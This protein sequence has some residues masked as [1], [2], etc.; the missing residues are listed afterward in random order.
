MER[1]FPPER[2]VLLAKNDCLTLIVLQTQRLVLKAL[3][4]AHGL[5][6]R[7]E[8][9][10]LEIKEINLAGGMPPEVDVKLEFKD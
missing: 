1:T 6:G 10:N 8:R 7:L 4:K 9:L 5:D 2:I 3:R